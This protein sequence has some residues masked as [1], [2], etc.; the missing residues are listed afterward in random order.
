M[1]SPTLFSLQDSILLLWVCRPFEQASKPYKT[2]YRH[3]ELEDALHRSIYGSCIT[4]SSLRRR[5]CC[6]AAPVRAAP[7][8]S[9]ERAAIE[10]RLRHSSGHPSGAPLQGLHPLHEQVGQAVGTLAGFQPVAHAAQLVVPAREQN[11]EKSYL[12]GDGRIRS[13]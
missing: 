10:I 12:G 11:G 7:V 4:A 8:R 1:T 3:V 5:N 13:R 9:R 2:P 6:S